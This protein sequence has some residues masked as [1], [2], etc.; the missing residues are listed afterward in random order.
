[1]RNSKLTKSIIILAILG[2]LIAG[3]ATYLHYKPT[4][5][6][7]CDLS[8]VFNCDLVYKSPYSKIFGIPVPAFG[9]L[10]Y[11]LLAVIAYTILSGKEKCKD[12]S[13]RKVLF[14]LSI[15]GVV[16]SLSMGAFVFYKLGAL[17][18]VCIT[19]YVV[20]IAI[21]VLSVKLKKEEPNTLAEEGNEEVNS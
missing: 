9:M 16:Y 21:L 10:F 4:D 6:G 2:F 8:E 18:P 14:Y 13:T 19:S 12:V 15:F 3:Y 1:M 5:G 11:A 20:I 7:V 17:C